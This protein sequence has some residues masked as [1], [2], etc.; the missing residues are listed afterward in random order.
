[1]AA[2]VLALFAVLLFV[3]DDRCVEVRP[4]LRGAEQ[5]VLLLVLVVA[6]VAVVL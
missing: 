6:F 3:V 5:V 2:E 4:R 1:V